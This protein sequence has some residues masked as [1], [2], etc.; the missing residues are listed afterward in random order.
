MRPASSRST[1]S[2][3]RTWSRACARSGHR[4]VERDRRTGRAGGR[5]AR[6]SSSRAT[7]SSASAPATSPNGPP[8]LADGDRGKARQRGMSVIADALPRVRGKLTADAPLAQAGL[9]QERRR[10]R[11]AVRAGGR[12]TTCC[13]FLRG[14]DPEVAGDGARPRLEPDRP[15]RRRAGRGRAARQGVRA[16]SSVLDRTTS[17]AAAAGR[18]ASSSPRPRATPASPGSSSCAA[19][20]A[21]SAASCG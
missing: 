10:G 9:V 1:A 11:L 8:G 4:S 12:S 5:A 14:L 2:I 19:F 16:R 6:K 3:P 20:P 7:W 21:P 18:A 13:D 15:R 17:C